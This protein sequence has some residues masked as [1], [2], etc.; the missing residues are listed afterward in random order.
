MSCG[1]ADVNGRGLKIKSKLK[2]SHRGNQDFQEQ[3]EKK[4]EFSLWTS[5]DSPVHALQVDGEDEV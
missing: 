3:I 1:L 4:K 2:A 5:S